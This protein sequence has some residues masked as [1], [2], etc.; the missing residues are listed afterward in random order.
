MNLSFA[1]GS[2]K[3]HQTAVGKPEGGGLRERP[4]VPAQ[5]TPESAS[6]KARVPPEAAMRVFASRAAPLQQPLQCGCVGSG[7]RNPPGFYQAL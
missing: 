6:P 4:G 2:Q 3:S 7:A 1:S 5:M